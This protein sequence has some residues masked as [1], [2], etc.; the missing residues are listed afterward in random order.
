MYMYI[1]NGTYIFGISNTMAEIFFTDISKSCFW[2]LAKFCLS[3][4][5]KTSKISF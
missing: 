3:T 1:W 4:R 5:S 2:N